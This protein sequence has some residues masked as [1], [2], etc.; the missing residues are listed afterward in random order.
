MVKVYYTQTLE[1]AEKLKKRWEEEYPYKPYM[2]EIT[3]EKIGNVFR[4]E[5][6]TVSLDQERRIKCI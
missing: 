1:E 5:L 4:V 6:N 3:V 2:S